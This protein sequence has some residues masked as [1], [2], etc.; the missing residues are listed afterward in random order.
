[1]TRLVRSAKNTKTASKKTR[2]PG[3]RQ[4]WALQDA[5]ASFSELVRRA[6][7]QGPQH[8][9]IHGKDAVVVVSAEQYGKLSIHAKYPTLSALMAS[10]PPLFDELD[11]ESK[12]VRMVVRPVDL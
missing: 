5:K 8:V 7:E 6:R 2:R 10:A 1:M 3:G 11:L 12:P 9:T 4:S